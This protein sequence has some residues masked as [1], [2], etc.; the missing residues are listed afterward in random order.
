MFRGLF[1]ALLP[2]TFR[3]ATFPLHLL[4]CPH[5]RLRFGD[6]C[7]FYPTVTPN[8]DKSSF[9]YLSPSLHT[10]FCN[11]QNQHSTRATGLRDSQWGKATKLDRFQD[12]FV[13]SLSTEQRRSI[14]GRSQTTSWSDPGWID[15]RSISKKCERSHSARIKAKS[16]WDRSSP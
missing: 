16:I 5:K 7:L 11:L 8:S 1:S 12:V 10:F 15:P 13:F 9:L 3:K 6:F 14:L 4:Q 2:V